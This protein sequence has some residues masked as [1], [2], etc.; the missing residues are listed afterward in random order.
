MSERVAHKRQKSQKKQKVRKMRTMNGIEKNKILSVAS[1]NA[2]SYLELGVDMDGDSVP[3]PN[4]ECKLS[5]GS[6]G[7]GRSG[8]P[9]TIFGTVDHVAILPGRK[10]RLETRVPILIRVVDS[11]ESCASASERDALGSRREPVRQ[12]QVQTAMLCLISSLMTYVMNGPRSGGVMLP[13]NQV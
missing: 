6:D 2:A 7:D 11:H 3:L 10:A 8:A 13:L 12:V 1:A 9:S 4:I 5:V